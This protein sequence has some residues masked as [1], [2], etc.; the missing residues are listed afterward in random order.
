MTNRTN[1]GMAAIYNG[2][3]QTGLGVG[4]TLKAIGNAA[5]KVKDFA[6][7]NKLATKLDTVVNAIPGAKGYLN[8]NTGGIYG[9]AIQQA[10]YAGY[11]RKRKSHK[12]KRG[13]CSKRK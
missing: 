13:G 4:Q 5:G 8:A 6:K 12:K 1:L 2:G 11:G 3:L 9:K 7:S 10:R